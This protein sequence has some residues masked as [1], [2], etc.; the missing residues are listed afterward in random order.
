MDAAVDAGSV[1]P[2]NETVV[3]ALS[4]T[5][6]KTD[7]PVAEPEK[8]ASLDDTL[9]AAYDKIIS[10]PERW[11]N[12]QFKSDA[13]APTEAKAPEVKAEGDT[14]SPDQPVEAAAEPAKPVIEPPISWSG[15]M[16]AKFASLPPEVQQYVAQRDK[17]S[18]DAISRFGQERKSLEEKVKNYEPIDQLVEAR[19]AEF[20]RRGV[21]PAQAF[22]VLLDAQA[23]LDS[24]PWGGLVQIAK[25][26]GIDLQSLIPGQTGQTQYG[27]NQTSPEVIALRNELG[28]IKSYL[29][30]QQ[31]RDFDAQEARK[32]ADAE[33]T[34][35]STAALASQIAEF[36]KDKS[37][38]KD[39]EDDVA[40]LIPA[41]R[42][43]NPNDKPLDILAKAYDAAIWANPAVR[44]RILADQRKADEEK[45]RAESVKKATDAKK[46][47]AVNVKSGTAGKTTP[48]SWTDTLESEADRLFAG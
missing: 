31:K 25:T 24:D 27:G 8:A 10:Q 21:T 44:E 30:E 11:P 39:V 36:S 41:I 47:A 14:K 12:G 5:E 45:R 42:A 35:K 20:A 1:E 7:T 3:A 26:Y 6:P 33:A 23:R 48:R 9:S 4:D 19:K 16:K 38:F 13:N 34:E 18:H 43:K 37:H 22:S 46:S 15:D 40:N 2:A 32:K 17:E 29:T 28:Q